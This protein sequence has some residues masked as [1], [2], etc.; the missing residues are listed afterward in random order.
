M[1]IASGIIALGP[2]AEGDIFPLYGQQAALHNLVLSRRGQF[3]DLDELIGDKAHAGTVVDTI[4]WRA[5]VQLSVHERHNGDLHLP[6]LT[7]QGSALVKALARSRGQRL[8]SPAL[9]VIQGSTARAEWCTSNRLTP[10][11]Y[12]NFIY[13]FSLLADQGQLLLYSDRPNGTRSF[14]V[15]SI[16]LDSPERSFLVLR[17][18]HLLY[19]MAKVKNTPSNQ[20]TDIAFYVNKYME[21]YPFLVTENDTTKIDP[22][23][24][25]LIF[26]ERLT[27]PL[28]RL[29]LRISGG[30]LRSF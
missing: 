5:T 4:Q 1:N 21:E 22:Q 25:S 20:P 15:E 19:W 26:T 3:V 17:S 8:H 6:H 27:E 10:H 30:P 9:L 18:H 16:S 11:S 13:L 24:C 2:F 7:A 23:V 12:F 29:T 28:V 14:V